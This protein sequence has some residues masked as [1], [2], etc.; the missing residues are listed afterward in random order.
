MM[1]VMNWEAPYAWI[2]NIVQTTL[3]GLQYGITATVYSICATFFGMIGAVMLMYYTNNA[4][5]VRL[6]YSYPITSA[7]AVVVGIVV[8]ILPLWRLKK[9]LQSAEGVALEE[10]VENEAISGR[11]L[12][13]GT[14]VTEENK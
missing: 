4:D 3:Q 6:M 11:L 5:F 8:I 7:F 13:G 10:V 2:R 9:P 1:K 12:E 14:I